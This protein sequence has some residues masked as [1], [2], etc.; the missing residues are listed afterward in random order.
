MSKCKV[1]KCAALRCRSNKN[2]MCILE[3]IEINDKGQCMQFD[4]GQ[5]VSGFH[6]GGS[7]K[8]PDVR[9]FPWKKELKRKEGIPW[10]SE[11]P[12]NKQ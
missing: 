5:G 3:F 8:S 12:F 9:N 4:D 1:R 2:A 7:P 11:L 10:K 6:M